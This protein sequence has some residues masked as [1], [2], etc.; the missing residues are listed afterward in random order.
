MKIK[1]SHTNTNLVNVT[2]LNRGEC[3]VHSMD[4]KRVYQVVDLNVFFQKRNKNCENS[5]MCV[6]IQNGLIHHTPNYC[7][8]YKVEVT[9][10][11]TYEV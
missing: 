9:A 11:V 3:Y 4:S 7:N 8:V 2:S 1:I 10:K 5:V 6:D